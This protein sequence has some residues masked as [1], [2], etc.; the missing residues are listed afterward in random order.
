[1][2]RI[3]SCVF[4]LLFTATAWAGLKN[5]D[6]EQGP[7]NPCF[8]FDIPAGSTLIP[9]WVVTQ[10]TIDWDGPPPCSV[11]PQRGSH[12]LD[13][14]GQIGFGGIAQTF[15]TI[16][17]KHYKLSFWLAGNPGAP[18]TIKPLAVNIDGVNVLNLTFSIAGKSASNMGW[19]HHRF[20]FCAA[21]T[22]TTI[23]FVSDVRPAGGT[24]NAGANLDNVKVSSAQGFCR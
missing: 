7:S 21:S 14:V 16:P 13:L 2:S 23:E 9:G 3:M 22:S 20:D 8:I 18:P 12:S 5:G 4:L 1:M 19:E 15:A 6:F 11:T 17:G 10:G 24:L